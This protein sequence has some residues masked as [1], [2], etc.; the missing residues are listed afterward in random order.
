MNAL[1][2]YLQEALRDLW[3]NKGR[4]FLTSLG[5]IIG[6]YSVILLLSLGEGLKIYIQQQFD[7]LGSNLIFVIP[8]KL[9]G[10]SGPDSMAGGA[11]FTDHDY[12]QLQLGLPE[13]VVVPAVIKSVTASSRKDQVATSLMGSNQNLSL[14]YNMLPDEGRFFS[15]SEELTGRKVVVMGSKIAEELFNSS[16]IGQ[17]L[18][19]NDLKFKVIG[20]LQSKGGGGLGGPSFDDYLYTPYKALYLLTNERTFYAFYIKANSAKDIELTQAKAERILLKNYKEED[21]SLNT[22][23]ELLTTISGI[24]NMVN[25]VLVGIAAISLL[26]GGIGI[27]NIMYV[28]VTERTKEIGIRRA[29]GAQENNILFQFLTLSLLLTFVGGLLGIVL[30]YLTSLAIYPF[31]PATITI[32]AVIVAFVVCG[33]IGVIF[34]VFP[35][36]KAAKLSPVEA[37]RYE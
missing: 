35:A 34:G 3:I 28:T 18:D 2:F 30:A 16:P 32:E 19:I 15:K 1:Q 25:G 14:V 5:I 8:G 13:A 11:K 37:I 33:F 6:V 12:R 23:E 20:V 36:R 21:F 31:F 26:V 29:I 24:F 9:E 4:S 10:S 7:S 27:T 22:Q 17:T